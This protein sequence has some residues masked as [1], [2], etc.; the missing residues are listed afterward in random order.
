M[1]T[2]WQVEEVK[3]LAESGMAIAPS[4]EF[5]AGIAWLAM[6]LNAGWHP[7]ERD[8]IMEYLAGDVK[9]PPVSVVMVEHGQEVAR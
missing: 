1:Q 8:R 2:V 7:Y 5:A 3:R 6:A 4:R 9:G